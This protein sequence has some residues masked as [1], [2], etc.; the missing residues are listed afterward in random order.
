MLDAQA[1]RDEI[2]SEIKTI[3]VEYF[4]LDEGDVLPSARLFEDLDMDSIDAVDLMVTLTEKT[5]KK[6]D[7]DAFKKV[8]TVADVVEAIHG[9]LAK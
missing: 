6:L 3:F 8:R 9:L 7:A 5:G 2:L 4:E 1:S